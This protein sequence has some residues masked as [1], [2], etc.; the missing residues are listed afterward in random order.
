MTNDYSFAC[1]SLYLWLLQWSLQVLLLPLLSTLYTSM[2]S[3]HA[4]F[5]SVFI[6]DPALTSFSLNIFLEDSS[7][8]TASNTF[9]LATPKPLI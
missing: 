8:F 6:E 2:Q 4:P 3:L 7:M 1:N 5:I 9:N